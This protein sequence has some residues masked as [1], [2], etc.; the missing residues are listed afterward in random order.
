MPPRVVENIDELRSLVGQE[1]GVSEWFTITQHLVDSFAEI[2]HDHQW[3]HIDAERAR[4]E[5]PYGATIAHG[6]LTLSLLSHLQKQVVHVQDSRFTRSINYGF[7]RL[8]FVSGVPV[9]S[10]VRARS[11]LKALD[12]IEGGVQF[13][14]LVNVELEGKE[15]PAIAAEWLG[16][17]YQ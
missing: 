14:W 17:L 4:R 5:S 8:R 16:R 12:D 3:I 11:T 2:T 6:F 15:K 10:R 13:T 7:N 1:I 9:G